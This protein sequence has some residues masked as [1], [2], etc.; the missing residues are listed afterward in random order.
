MDQGNTMAYMRLQGRNLEDEVMV[1]KILNFQEKCPKIFSDDHIKFQFS[2]KVSEVYSM[3]Q[4]AEK[5]MQDR[6][7]NQL[8]QDAN[9]TCSIYICINQENV[10]S[11]NTA[12][13][14]ANRSTS[15]DSEI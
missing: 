13:N 10:Q 11:Q 14:E 1:C 6:Q 9:N 3:S 2:P 15:L 8:S 4:N 12:L 5:Y 7:I